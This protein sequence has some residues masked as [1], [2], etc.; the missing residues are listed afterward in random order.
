MAAS[1]SNGF[2]PKK[3]SRHGRKTGSPRTVVASNIEGAFANKREL[4]AA[5]DGQEALP[6]ARAQT[7]ESS[8][9]GQLKAVT[10]FAGLAWLPLEIWLQHQALFVRMLL[11]LRYPG[12]H[13]SCR[14]SD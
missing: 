13:P 8:Y 5:C 12:L 7:G 10:A 4:P 3:S 9:G 1:T 6:T 11:S 14:K 2:K